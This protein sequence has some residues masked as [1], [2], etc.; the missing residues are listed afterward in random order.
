[1]YPVEVYHLDMFP[2][3]LYISRHVAFIAKDQGQD[4]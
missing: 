2:I 4:S 1:M 3:H